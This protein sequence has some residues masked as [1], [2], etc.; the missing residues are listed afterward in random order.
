MP[1]PLPIGPSARQVQEGRQ[2]LRWAFG[3]ILPGVG[4][5]AGGHLLIFHIWGGA[6]GV[7]SISASPPHGRARPQSALACVI[8]LSLTAGLGA[9][10]ATILPFVDK[11]NETMMM[12]W[13]LLPS[14]CIKCSLCPRHG[15]GHCLILPNLPSIC[16]GRGSK[17]CSRMIS[18]HPRHFTFMSS[19]FH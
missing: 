9:G 8:S 11:E 10:R 16:R 14:S 4:G 7:R 17:R 5:A 13:S 15:A 1:S 12:L 3:A 18:A 2:H 6:G 19:F